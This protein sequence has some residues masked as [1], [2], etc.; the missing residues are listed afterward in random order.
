MMSKLKRM[1]KISHLKLF[2][3]GRWL[4][5]VYLIQRDENENIS[6]CMVEELIEKHL[7]EL[8]RSCISDE[9][10][11]FRTGFAFLHFGNRGVDLTV[12]HFGKW[13]E[14]FETYCCSWYCY[15]RD[16]ESMELLDSA[17]PIICQYEMEYVVQEISAVC[18]ILK[19][20]A[21]DFNFRQ[22]FENYYAKLSG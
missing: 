7:S 21:E 6:D 8:E 2:Q 9:F 13:G 11:Y 5:N 16:I 10:E 3:Y 15:N 19:D 14:T 12:W 4:L 22:A 20:E 1:T 17:E 18:N